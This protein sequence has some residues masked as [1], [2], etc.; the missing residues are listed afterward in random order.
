MELRTIRKKTRPFD[1]SA[2]GSGS[3][4][5]RMTPDEFLPPIMRRTSRGYQGRQTPFEPKTQ[6][7]GA[8]FPTLD[9]PDQQ[10]RLK[11]GLSPTKGPAVRPQSHVSKLTPSTAR[12]NNTTDAGPQTLSRRAIPFDTDEPKWMRQ[13]DDIE[14]GRRRA[15]GVELPK[16]LLTKE[17]LDDTNWDLSRHEEFLEECA[18]SEEERS[19]HTSDWN[20]LPPSLKIATV[21]AAEEQAGDWKGAVQALCL[22]SDQERLARRLLL[23]YDTRRDDE[24]ARQKMLEK[25]VHTM[26]VNESTG[27]EKFSRAKH[28]D[29]LEKYGYPGVPTQDLDM[30]TNADVR[31]AKQYLADR[32]LDPSLLQFGKP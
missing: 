31:K 1:S 28:H 27:G 11:R 13:L 2:Q 29:L 9:H 12:S 6:E 3:S 26:I 32:G 30:A 5:E 17:E 20:N 4:P 7:T 18:S 15:K 8:A 23:E 10:E 21:S 25:A 24:D 22:D 16:G 19:A 14:N